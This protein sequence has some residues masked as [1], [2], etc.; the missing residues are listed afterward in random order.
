MSIIATVDGEIASFTIPK[1]IDLESDVVLESQ[2]EADAIGAPVLAWLLSNNG[3]EY[4]VIS[5]SENSTQIDVKL[6]GRGWQDIA[7]R[8]G[9]GRSFLEIVKNGFENKFITQELAIISPNNP[10]YYNSDFIDTLQDA[11]D[12]FSKE[13]YVS[14]HGGEIAV[15]GY[16]PV[17]KILSLAFSGA[18]ATACGPTH[19]EAARTGTEQVLTN[20][21]CE[22]F[23]GAFDRSKMDFFIL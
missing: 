2:Q 10:E 4:V 13:S 12:L 8:G 9:K 1:A 14:E 23:P 18:C 21:L 17:K 6:S 16:D 15:V 19:G 11:V 5:P 22:K 7:N 3:F 20:H